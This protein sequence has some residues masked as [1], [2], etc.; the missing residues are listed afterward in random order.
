M[1]NLIAW[2]RRGPFAEFDELVRKAFGPV[3][4]WPGASDLSPAS[5]IVRDGDDALGRMDL[6]GVD[7]E[8]DV[9]VE[10]ENGQLVVRG[11]RKTE[12]SEA[13]LREVRY[14]SLRRTFKLPAQASP[15]D[16]TAD[17]ESGV[18]TVRV[19]GVHKSVEPQRIAVTSHGAQTVEQ[20]RPAVEA[21]E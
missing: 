11:E 8:K 2:G 12:T 16:I 13:T 17:Y 20:E 3:G 18:L 19:A 5:E 9:T 6:P 15:E 4:T 10:V 7:V 1:S 14:G 21:G